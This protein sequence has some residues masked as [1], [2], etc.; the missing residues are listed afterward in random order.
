MPILHISHPSEASRWLAKYPFQ[1]EVLPL[2]L[3]GN[4]SSPRDA[5]SVF[6]RMNM[7][8][9]YQRHLDCRYEPQ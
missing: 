3:P 8:G 9:C 7:G 4:I 2:P 6:E 1:L 5:L